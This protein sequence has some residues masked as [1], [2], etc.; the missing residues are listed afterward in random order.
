MTI[1][2]QDSRAMTK[3]AKRPSRRP[4]DRAVSALGS[5]A[6]LGPPLLT[7]RSGRS[8]KGPERP[9]LSRG[10]HSTASSPLL[11]LSPSS[12]SLNLLLMA[13]SFRW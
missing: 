10:Q 5:L 9:A 2:D 4:H 8:P 11:G 1:Y 3:L 12:P 13:A 7:N 6:A